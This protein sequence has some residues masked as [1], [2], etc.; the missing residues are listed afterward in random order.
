MNTFNCIGGNKGFTL[1]ELKELALKKDKDK[2]KLDLIMKFYFEF[3]LKTEIKLL[4]TNISKG[5][6]LEYDFFLGNNR[7]IDFEQDC[8]IRYDSNIIKLLDK[9]E[10]FIYKQ[11]NSNNN[12]YYSNVG[13]EEY[14]DLDR[15][16]FNIEVEIDK[17]YYKNILKKAKNI[18]VRLESDYSKKD[19]KQKDKS[20]F[21]KEKGHF[22]KKVNPIGIKDK[23]RRWEENSHILY[24]DK[25]GHI[26]CIKDNKIKKEDISFEKIELINKCFFYQKKKKYATHLYYLKKDTPQDRDISNITNNQVY[27]CHKRVI[28]DFKETLIYESTEKKSDYKAI[29]LKNQDKGNFSNNHIN[30]F[31]FGKSDFLE[32]E[33]D[34]RLSNRSPKQQFISRNKYKVLYKGYLEKLKSIQFSKSVKNLTLRDFNYH[35][36]EFYKKSKEEIKEKNFKDLKIEDTSIKYH[37]FINTI[38]ISILPN[39]KNQKGNSKIDELAL[40]LNNIL[41]IDT[42]KS[43]NLYL[44]I[45]YRFR[46]SIAHGE[47][48][49]LDNE[50]VFC[51]TEHD[52][53]LFRARI[54]KNKIHD[55]MQ[56]LQDNL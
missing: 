7:K 5:D 44:K 55:F 30:I 14:V 1:D 24:K 10:N 3:L 12:I 11:V 9:N 35:W 56:E 46:N 18:Y 48:K 6:I 51:N 39:Q 40:N 38:S 13:K 43:S 25:E 47:F 20:F 34:M 23:Y 33:Y 28:F 4:D 49:I 16:D 37:M 41:M 31:N 15:R 45:L 50:I 52:K 42:N 8:F 2:K 27:F 22:V 21:D 19:N 54:E 29:V 36:I 17:L 53:I 26:R 32:M